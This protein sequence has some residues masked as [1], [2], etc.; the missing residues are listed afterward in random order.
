MVLNLELEVVERL[1]QS[2]CMDAH[3]Y[4]ILYSMQ[5]LFVCNCIH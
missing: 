5:H 4:S 3:V 1:L 2:V